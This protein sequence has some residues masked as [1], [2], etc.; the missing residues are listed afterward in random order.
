MTHLTRGLRWKEEAL[1]S[2]TEGTMAIRKI[3]PCLWFNNQAEAAAAFLRLDLRAF[4]DPRI[5]RY[6]EEGGEVQSQNPGPC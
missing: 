6:A 1:A 5:A 2:E 3:I 4:A